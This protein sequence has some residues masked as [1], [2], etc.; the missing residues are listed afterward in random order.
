MVEKEKKL[1]TRIDGNKALL[2]GIRDRVGRIETKLDN[3]DRKID[4]KFDTLMKLFLQQN[5]TSR[6]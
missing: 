3:L 4:A 1:D 6:D 5:Q 2:M